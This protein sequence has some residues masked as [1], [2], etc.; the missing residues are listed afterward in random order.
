MASLH[1]D[2]Q[3][4]VSAAE[5]WSAVRDFHALH[6]RLVP[7][8]VVDSR[9]DGD[10]RVVTFGSGSTA[11]ERLVTVDDARRRL[12][13]SVVESRLGLDHHQSSVEILDTADGCRLVWTTDVLPDSVAPLIDGL[14]SQGAA[15][16][17]SALTPVR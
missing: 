6:T 13:Y 8:F 12:V 11:R 15:A 10:D 14:M 17:A 4:D 7:G 3:L 9:P 5:A 1:H 16:M 2:I